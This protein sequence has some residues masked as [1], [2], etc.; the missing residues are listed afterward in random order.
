M[1]D[2]LKIPG[3]ARPQGLTIRIG[4]GEP[5]TSGGL[6]RSDIGDFL[7][8]AQVLV[9]TKASEEDDKE[10]L[11]DSKRKRLLHE[12]DAMR[13]VLHYRFDHS[14]NHGSTKCWR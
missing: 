14:C 10:G 2:D 7:D 3:R 4:I 1:G 8:L 12:I 9:M 11:S 6:N 13:A 5:M